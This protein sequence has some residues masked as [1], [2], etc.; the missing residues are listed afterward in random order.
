MIAAAT[1]GDIPDRMSATKAAFAALTQRAAVPSPAPRG[2]YFFGD[3]CSPDATQALMSTLALF[4]ST[5]SL[6]C[7]PRR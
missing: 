1:A 7:F 6:L 5:S 4:T 2:D 3:T